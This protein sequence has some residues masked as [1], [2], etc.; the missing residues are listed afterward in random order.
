MLFFDCRMPPKSQLGKPASKS[1]DDCCYT[2]FSIEERNP[3]L[4]QSL[5]VRKCTITLFCLTFIVSIQAA[6]ML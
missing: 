1:V 3:P 4:R 5:P 2:E 6:F